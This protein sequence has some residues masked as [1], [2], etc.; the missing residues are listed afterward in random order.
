MR[1]FSP[2]YTA[3]AIEEGQVDIQRVIEKQRQEEAAQLLHKFEEDKKENEVLVNN[4][5]D[6]LNM[7]SDNCEED[8]K[9]IG[10]MHVRNLA[11]SD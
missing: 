7:M 4:E 8:M 6:G 2:L 9:K 1:L 10:E 5:I 11:A 3:K